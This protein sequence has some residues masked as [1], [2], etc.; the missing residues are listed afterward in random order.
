VGFND[1]SHF[2]RTFR[3]VVGCSPTS[4]RTALRCA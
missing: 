1:L 3:K 4:Y 2:D